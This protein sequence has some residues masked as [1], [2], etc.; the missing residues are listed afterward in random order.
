VGIPGKQDKMGT[1][2]APDVKD[3]SGDSKNNEND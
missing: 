1:F 3:T 2:V